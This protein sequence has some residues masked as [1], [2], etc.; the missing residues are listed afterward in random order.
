MDGIHNQQLFDLNLRKSLAKTKVNKD[1]F[2]SIENQ[3]E[4][5]KF[6]LYNNGITIIC[7]NLDVSEEDKIKIQDYAVVN[8]CQSLSC[9][10]TKKDRGGENFDFKTTYKSPRLLRELK[11]EIL[12]AYK[13]LINRGRVESFSQLMNQQ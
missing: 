1:I 8:G 10:Y 2:Q 4:H 7:G 12:K 3:S 6:L 11:S 9:F 5:N 13:K